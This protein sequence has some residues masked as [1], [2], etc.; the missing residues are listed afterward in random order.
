VRVPFEYAVVRIVPH[1]DREEF[2]NAGVLLFCEA[3]N[4]LRATIELDENRLCAL[5]PNLDLAL[6]AEHLT[7]FERV[8]RGGAQA[9]PLEKLSL[10]ERW[11]WLTAPRST[12]LQT[13][14]PHGGVAEDLDAVVER[15]LERMVR[16]PASFAA[17]RRS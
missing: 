2:V 13:S 15:V 5:C 6:V 8:C 1:V 14:A 17:S 9:G 10:R 3:K 12:I 11:R 4:L 16:R 7:G